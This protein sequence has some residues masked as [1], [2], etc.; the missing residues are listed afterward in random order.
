MVL[1]SQKGAYQMDA[2][3]YREPANVSA[4]R[5]VTCGALLPGDAALCGTCGMPVPV[6]A[7][8]P[9]PSPTTSEPAPLP[10]E[11]QDTASMAATISAPS[12]GQPQT[13]QPPQPEGPVQRCNWCGAQNAV[14][15]EHCI[16]CNA[17]FPKSEQDDLLT[18]ASR[19]RVRLAMEE[20]EEVD[21]KRSRSFLARL[22]G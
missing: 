2:N 16:S 5:C 7:S 8:A 20:F 10:V 17:A 15:A 13:A 22:F 12:E 19:E 14:G 9:A 3:V 21:R 6:G 18:R 4:A 1:H 11:R